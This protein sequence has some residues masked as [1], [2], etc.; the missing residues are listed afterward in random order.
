DRFRFSRSG[1]ADAWK[2]VRLNP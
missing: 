1:I 2:I